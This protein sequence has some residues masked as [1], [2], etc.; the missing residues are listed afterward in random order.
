M[1]PDVDENIKCFVERYR[2]FELRWRGKGL[3]LIRK[4]PKKLFDCDF[5]IRANN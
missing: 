2:N 4:Y 5:G 1:H 3:I